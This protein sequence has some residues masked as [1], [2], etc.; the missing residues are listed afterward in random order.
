[1]VRVFSRRFFCGTGSGGL[2]GALT[3]DCLTDAGTAECDMRSARAKA[4]RW[5]S[6][7][8]IDGETRR[9]MHAP[10]QAERSHSD[11]HFDGLEALAGLSSREN[12]VLLLCR[13]L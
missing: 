7:R 2:A 13:Q 3:A 11:S 4:E 6:L 8:K 9:N 12:V 5:P 10:E 1:M